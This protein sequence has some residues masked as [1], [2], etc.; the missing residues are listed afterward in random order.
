MDGPDSG[1][2]AAS[3]ASTALPRVVF[4]ALGSRGDVQPL[5]HLA[6]QL[7][8]GG[9]A[10]VHCTLYVAITL[11]SI[12]EH[13]RQRWGICTLV[14]HCHTLILCVQSVLR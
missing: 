13:E 1:G 5:A 2:C 3:R 12:Y 14:V 4:V 8:R 6:H 9:Q 11:H 10:D 7:A